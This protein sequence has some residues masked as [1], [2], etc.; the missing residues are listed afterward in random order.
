MVRKV[1]S[2]AGVGILSAAVGLTI[3]IAVATLVSAATMGIALPIAAGGL[4]IGIAA[5]VLS[6]RPTVKIEDY[7]H[8]LRYI[9]LAINSEESVLP[10]E[11]NV[12]DYERAIIHSAENSNAWIH[13]LSEQFK[14][15]NLTTREI[16]KN[17][18]EVTLATDKS[19][20]LAKED[21]MM[22]AV[23]G[24]ENA[25][26]STLIN[27][28]I[29][30]PPKDDEENQ[31]KATTGHMSHT[32]DPKGYLA[33]AVGNLVAVDFP[34][35]QAAD[36]RRNLADMWEAFERLP[37]V[38]VVMLRFSGD[39]TANCGELPRRAR[40][41]FC[42]RVVLIVNK[43]DSVM[44]GRKTA[45]VWKEFSPDRMNELREAYKRLLDHLFARTAE[46]SLPTR[47]QLLLEVRWRG[48]AA[49]QRFQNLL[50][51][52]Q[53]MPQILKSIFTKAAGSIRNSKYCS[54]STGKETFCE[55]PPKE[56]YIPSMNS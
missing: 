38:C 39:V 47:G 53:E 17:L 13:H 30:G 1:G 34:G 35:M 48:G 56:K 6:N 15:P 41:K 27:I 43:V 52:K 37:D 32:D 5:L 14:E 2:G 20:E 40:D 31:D 10:P 16:V 4:A 9:H 11:K 46:K 51:S 49:S 55:H 18:V 50:S 8:V 23:V 19:V 7:S 25:G 42:K 28:L 29:N 26:K 24:P 33:L 21:K 45:P 22:L 54:P 36:E 12:A 44:K 3:Y